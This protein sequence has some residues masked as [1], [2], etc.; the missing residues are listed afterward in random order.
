M[1]FV[2]GGGG[3]WGGGAS[4]GNTNEGGYEHAPSERQSSTTKSKMGRHEKKEKKERKEKKGKNG[5][6]GKG[7]PLPNGAMVAH[8]AD[9]SP[10]MTACAG[11]GKWVHVP[12]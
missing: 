10:K 9:T 8:H 6:M 11:G 5:Q 12:N 3:K 7:E 2:Q 4:R 1:A